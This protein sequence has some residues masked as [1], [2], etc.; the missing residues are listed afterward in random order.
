MHGKQAEL[1]ESDATLLM[2]AQTKLTDQ[3]DAIKEANVSLASQLDSKEAELKGALQTVS[4]LRQ[5][6]QE[7]AS[8]TQEL[9]HA[10]K[11]NDQ[12]LQVEHRSSYHVHCCISIA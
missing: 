3:L 9:Q 8:L 12:A 5:Q 1:E 2:Q 11:T 4:S 6:I 10:A 7:S